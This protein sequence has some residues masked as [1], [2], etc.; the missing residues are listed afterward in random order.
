MRYSSTRWLILI[1]LLITATYAIA[2]D[3]TLTTYYP[4]PRGVYAQLRIGVGTPAV[5]TADLYVLKPIDDG[6]FAFRI[7]DLP[8]PD[9]TPFVITQTGNVRVQTTAPVSAL[10]VNGTITGTGLTCVNGVNSLPSP[11]AR[12]STSTSPRVP[13]LAGWVVTWRLVRSPAVRA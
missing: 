10:D 4:S 8:N 5:T 2:E 7:D 3:V 9:N 12:S 6:N 13:S 1:L 11:T